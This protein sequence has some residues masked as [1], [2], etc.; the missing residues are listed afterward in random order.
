M[1]IEAPLQPAH[2]YDCM[3]LADHRPG[4]I[5]SGLP[6]FGLLPGSSTRG[7]VITPAC[8]LAN[9]KCETLSFLPI[10]SASQYLGSVS[11]R[12]E[13]WLEIESLLAKFE[14]INQHPKP[15]RFELISGAALQDIE[16]Y[17][18]DTKGKKIS[19]DDR[20]RLLGYCE[21]VKAAEAGS[22]TASHLANFIKNDR[23]KGLLSRL[24]TNSMK[25]D[26]HFL[27]A[28]GSSAEYSPTPDHSVVLFRY[29]L[30]VPIDLLDRAQNSSFA[31]WQASVAAEGERRSV[32][33]SMPNWPIKLAMLKGEF[34]AD[35]IS[36]YLNMYIR[37]GSTD[38]QEQSVRD[39]AE[40]IKVQK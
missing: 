37:L 14:L 10:V 9:R 31:L 6:T 39:I 12:Y 15:T 4:D 27:P 40:E 29:P 33:A 26:I 38:F 30:T 11:F 2:F 13:C 22:A 20:A 35:L 21:Y 5:W 19:E 8:D 25:A 17:S 28:E 24:V 16:N 7:V 36:R 18:Q 23:L 34:F 32:L 3:P 1:P